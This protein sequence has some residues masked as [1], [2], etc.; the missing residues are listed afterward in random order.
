M[1]DSNM[2]IPDLE[3]NNVVHKLIDHSL[4]PFIIFGSFKI[5]KAGV[6]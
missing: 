5:L 6:K 3:F 4:K 2:S 1:T